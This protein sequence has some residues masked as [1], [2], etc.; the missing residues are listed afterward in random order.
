MEEKIFTIRLKEAMQKQHKKQV[1]LL[2]EAQAANVRLSKSQMSQYVSGRA[3]PRQNIGIFLAKALQVT[4]A[5][6]YGTDNIEHT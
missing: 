4:P 5:W 2:R 3:V 6:L 1:D